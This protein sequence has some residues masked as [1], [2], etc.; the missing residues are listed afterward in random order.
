MIHLLNSFIIL[1]LGEKYILENTI[2]NLMIINYFIMGTRGTVD[3][4]NFAYGHYADVWAAWTEVG[5]NLSVTVIG[6]YWFGIPGILFGKIASLVPIIVFWKP[7]YLFHQGFK[8]SYR[9]YWMRTLRYY[10]IFVSSWVIVE[11]L[12][13]AVKI[14]PNNSYGDW[15][16]YA[17]MYTGVFTILYFIGL[18]YFGPGGKSLLQRLPLGKRVFNCHN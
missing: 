14:N 16:I 7:Y 1:W 3:N 18:A 11:A 10:L 8:L 4:F 6:G 12:L 5:I 13:K 2:L 9:Y 15:I 17:G